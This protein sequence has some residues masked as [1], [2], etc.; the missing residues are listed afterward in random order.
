[1]QLEGR[2]LGTAS[3]VVNLFQYPL[4][5]AKSSEAHELNLKAFLV[6]LSRTVRYDVE[7]L[8]E[9][10]GRRVLMPD[11]FPYVLT[12]HAAKVITNVRFR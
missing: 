11:S 4:F 7:K 12:A 9:S 8:Q 2:V 10:E 3:N 6:A 1:M 5:H